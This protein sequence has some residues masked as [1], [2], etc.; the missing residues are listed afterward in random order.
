MNERII[1][2]PLQESLPQG[3]ELLQLLVCKF[4]DGRSSS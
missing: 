2:N 4:R 1:K 3:R